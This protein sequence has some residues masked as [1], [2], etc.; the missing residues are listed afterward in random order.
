LLHVRVGAALA[1]ELAP[2]ETDENAVA[3]RHP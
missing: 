1:A 3:A 2:F